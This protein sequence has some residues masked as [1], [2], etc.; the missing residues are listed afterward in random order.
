MHSENVS[1]Q[2]VPACAAEVGSGDFR[3]TGF[4]AYPSPMISL[5]VVQKQNTPIFIEF[6]K[7]MGVNPNCTVPV[8]T[9]EIKDDTVASLKT[10][11][12]TK[13]KHP[14]KTPNLSF[15]ARQSPEVLHSGQCAP[16]SLFVVPC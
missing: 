3:P 15:L 10:V 9:W 11:P 13:Q 12:G 7:C 2:W 16:V 6:Q 5:W 1:P 14:G 4:L 8:V